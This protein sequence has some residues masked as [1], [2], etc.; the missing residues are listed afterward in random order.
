MQHQCIQNDTAPPEVLF[1]ITHGG[2]HNIMHVVSLESILLL[3]QEVE[4]LCAV[5]VKSSAGLCCII[6]HDL[7]CARVNSSRGNWPS[8]KSLAPA[9]GVA[10]H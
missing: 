4:L 9:C 3:T 1:E 7:D 10:P 8:F 2:V 6:V 5:M